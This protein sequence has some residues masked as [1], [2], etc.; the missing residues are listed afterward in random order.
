M[1]HAPSYKN[2]P[3]FKDGRVDEYLRKQAE[4]LEAEMGVYPERMGYYYSGNKKLPPPTPDAILY[5]LISD[6]DVLNYSDFED[7]AEN[8]GYDSDSIKALKVYQDCLASALK[9]NAC[10]GA[11]TIKQLQ[12]Y[13]QDY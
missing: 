9:L 10:L 4:H 13:F 2:P 3:R 1:G 5:A 6:A 8:F 7:W 11:G 12:E